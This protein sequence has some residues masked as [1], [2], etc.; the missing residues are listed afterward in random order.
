MTR[1]KR[2]LTNTQINELKDKLLSSK[3]EILN[4]GHQFDIYYLDQNELIDHVD[5]AS[6]NTQKSEELRFRNREIF[7]LK[8]IN[9]TLEKIKRGEYGNCSECEGPIGFSR[10]WA[11]PVADM[12]IDCKEESEKD[13]KGNFFGRQ[14]KSKGVAIHE[15]SF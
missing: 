13:E 2:H 3:E 15:M 9:K 4:K 5:E 10:L 6:E 7:F 11:R 14:S 8:K 1:A 12:C